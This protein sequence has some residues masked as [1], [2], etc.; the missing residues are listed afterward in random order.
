MQRNAERRRT[1]HRNQGV[2]KRAQ[3][4]TK[5]APLLLLKA[6]AVDV[7]EKPVN[8]GVLLAAIKLG[9]QRSRERSTDDAEC[10]ELERRYVTLPPRQ[11]EFFAL[12]TAGL[13]NKEVGAELGISERTVKVHR[14]RLRR[15]MGTDSL[16]ELSR[17]AGVLHIT[18]RIQTYRQNQ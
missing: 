17:M 18:S 11:R 13:L 5:F 10:L 7:L 14:E 16:A 2:R 6:G 15:K 1:Q 3:Y 12:I 8:D 4:G 9:V